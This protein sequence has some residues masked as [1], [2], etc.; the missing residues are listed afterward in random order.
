MNNPH[1]ARGARVFEF[2]LTL[3]ELTLTISIILGLSSLLIAGTSLYASHA[4]KA[5]CVMAQNQM[6]K[7]LVSYSN[8]TNLSLKSGVDYYS[9]PDYAD[10]FDERLTCPESGGT[11][12]IVLDESGRELVIT[13]NDHGEHHR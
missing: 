3:P 7:A 6:R 1:S 13:C 12:S 2:G 5:S 10:V 4:D 9:E 8:M 11:Y